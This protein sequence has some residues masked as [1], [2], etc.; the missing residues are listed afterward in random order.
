MTP[1]FFF[2][3]TYSPFHSWSC[4]WRGSPSSYANHRRAKMANYWLQVAH[5]QAVASSQQILERLRAS[6]CAAPP[7]A[8]DDGASIAAGSAL[9]LSER[10]RVTVQLGHDREWVMVA[11]VVINKSSSWLKLSSPS[12]CHHLELINGQVCSLGL[13]AARRWVAS[14]LAMYKIKERR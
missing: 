11:M 4:P 1:S 7:T 3:I 10:S 5:P 2:P 13:A 14:L 6:G 9:L 12:T 8:G